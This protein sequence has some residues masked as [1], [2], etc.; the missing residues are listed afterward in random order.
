MPENY[1][2]QFLSLAGE[3]ER[4][5]TDG[6]RK[7]R[8]RF[9]ASQ[10]DALTRVF[11][12]T[13]SPKKCVVQALAAETRLS[14]HSVKI[15]F[16]NRRQR[17]WAKKDAALALITLNDSRESATPPRT[18]TPAAHMT[19]VAQLREHPQLLIPPAICTG[20]IAVGQTL[21]PL[22]LPSSPHSVSSIFAPHLVAV[23]PLLGAHAHVFANFELSGGDAHDAA[24]PPAYYE[25]RYV[26]HAV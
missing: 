19:N 1:Q 5:G 11:D 13:P 18:P 9:S 2:D 15:W 17:S 4:R 7:R 21:S 6:G 10:I 16:Q 26:V 3:G 14:E 24:R 20:A 12:E 22:S 25:V 23:D 8:P